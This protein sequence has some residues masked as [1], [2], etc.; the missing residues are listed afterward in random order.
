M[1]WDAEEE[2]KGGR[3]K[4]TVKGSERSPYSALARER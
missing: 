3:V 1:K 4:V 2:V